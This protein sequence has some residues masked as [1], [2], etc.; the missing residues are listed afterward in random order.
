MASS[1]VGSPLPG[2]NVQVS[3]AGA[4]WKR[5]RA[6]ESP[7]SRRVT[8][9]AGGATAPMAVSM[10]TPPSQR[11]RVAAFTFTAADVGGKLE[12]LRA[13]V[14]TEFAKVHGDIVALQDGSLDYIGE[15]VF[16]AVITANNGK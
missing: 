1:S 13:Q 14:M 10:G 3:A 11:Q 9:G 16:D 5:R 8:G 4:Q 7:S 2:R 12:E 15:D 6:V